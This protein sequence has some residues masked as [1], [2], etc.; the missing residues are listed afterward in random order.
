MYFLNIYL[1]S[2]YLSMLLK[3]TFLLL[4]DETVYLSCC[5]IICSLFIVFEENGSEH[6]F[7]NMFCTKLSEV[8]SVKEFRLKFRSQLSKTF[9]AA[10][11]PLT[12]LSNAIFAVTFWSVLTLFHHLQFGSAWIGKRWWFVKCRQFSN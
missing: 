6:F 4:V 3:F 5:Y 9:A 8:P 7:I 11:F 12:K 2:W 10:F 1:N